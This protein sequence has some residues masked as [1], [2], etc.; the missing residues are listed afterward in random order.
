MYC[1]SNIFLILYLVIIIRHF[2]RLGIFKL[3]L[4]HLLH[5]VH[6]FHPFFP[7]FVLPCLFDYVFILEV[8]IRPGRCILIL[9]R[10]FT[11]I[12]V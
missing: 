4:E 2:I 6:L 5:F 3:R 8:L 10:A 12:V 11:I 1:M 7:L 9:S